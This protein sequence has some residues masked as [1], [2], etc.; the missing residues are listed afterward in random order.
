MNQ[1]IITFILLTLAA[2]A[3]VQAK[4]KLTDPQRRKKSEV[5][6]VVAN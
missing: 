6:K 3:E 2:K 4:S 5:R 1:V